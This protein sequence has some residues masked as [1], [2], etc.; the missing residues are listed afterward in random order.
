MY[1]Q[2]TADLHYYI[3]QNYGTREIAKS[4]FDSKG[5]HKTEKGKSAKSA[6]LFVRSLGEI[7]LK[8]WKFEKWFY[9]MYTDENKLLLNINELLSATAVQ[10]KF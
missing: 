7:L 1:N 6:K 5:K 4:L 9:R 3:L 2:C 10:C 8:I